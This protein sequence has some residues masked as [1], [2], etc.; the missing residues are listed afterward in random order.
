MVS[1][2]WVVV[3]VVERL[4]RAGS[5]SGSRYTDSRLCCRGE[6]E[7]ERES[8]RERERERERVSERERE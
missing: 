3:V 4:S 6:R 7:R 5:E 1:K 2:R 8:E